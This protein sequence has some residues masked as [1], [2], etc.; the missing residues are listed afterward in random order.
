MNCR[1]LRSLCL[2]HIG[3]N[4]HLKPKQAHNYKDKPE[5]IVQNQVSYTFA[6]IR[7]YHRN[8]PMAVLASA[9]AITSSTAPSGLDCMAN[10]TF[11]SNERMASR[12]PLVS[13]IFGCP[14]EFV[15]GYRRASVKLLLETLSLIAEFVFVEVLAAD[16]E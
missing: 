16:L 9:L 12:I 14:L 7:A 13:R 1:A 5:I 10:A 3:E 4:R 6:T 15:V 11:L 2:R 8:T